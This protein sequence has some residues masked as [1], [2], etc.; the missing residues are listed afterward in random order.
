MGMVT[1]PMEVRHPG[2]FLWI[3]NYKNKYQSWDTLVCTCMPTYPAH[4]LQLPNCNVRSKIGRVQMDEFS[5]A[6]GCGRSVCHWASVRARSSNTLISPWRFLQF[7]IK[8]RW[9]FHLP[10]ACISFSTTRCSMNNGNNEN[11]SSKALSPS[12]RP[13]T[14][15]LLTNY[16]CID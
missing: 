12:Q 2:S 6:S 16:I 4:P 14:L 9:V 15:Q 5:S 13:H 1:L 3:V 8:Q 10:A 7:M 11:M